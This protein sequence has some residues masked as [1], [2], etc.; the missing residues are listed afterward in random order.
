MYGRIL[1]KSQKSTTIFENGNCISLNFCS[2]HNTGD[3]VNSKDELLFKCTNHTPLKKLQETFEYYNKKIGFLEKIK[4]FFKE[5]GYREVITKKLKKE[6]VKEPN[7]SYIKTP[8][9]YL[10]S[11]PE[12]EI[13]KLLCLG[14]DKLFEICYAYRDDFEDGLH[15]KEFLILEWY[16]ALATPIEINREFVELIKHLNGGS[17][18]KYRDYRVDLDKIEFVTYKELFK[19]Y[20]S[21]DIEDFDKE[22]EKKKHNID[23]TNDKNEILDAIFSLKIQKH[24]GI[25]HPTVVHDFPKERAALS[26]IENGYAKRYELYIATL[27]LSNCYLEETDPGEIKRRFKE[28]DSEFVKALEFGMPPTSG[29]AVG[30]DRLFMVLNSLDS[31]E[32]PKWLSS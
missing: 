19:K 16:R 12:V 20:A 2:K 29:I 21:L 24:L 25:Y 13:K 28:I 31:I 18:V 8:Y 6:I 15:K 1:N 32:E 23:G 14:F 9:G 7:I 26:K 11:S 22:A 30:V 17:V 3:I 27:E 10:A 5:R 4:E